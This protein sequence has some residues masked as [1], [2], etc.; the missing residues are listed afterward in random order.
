MAINLTA[1]LTRETSYQELTRTSSFCIFGTLSDNFAHKEW[2]MNESILLINYN[3]Q[4][5]IANA[6]NLLLNPFYFNFHK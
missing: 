3:L 5:E 6:S 2:L 1:A 4:V